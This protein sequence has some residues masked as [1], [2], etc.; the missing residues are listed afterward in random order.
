MKQERAVEV[1]QE[2]PLYETPYG[3]G[4][5][6]KIEIVKGK[7]DVKQ[8]IIK[9]EHLDDIDG[10]LNDDIVLEEPIEYVN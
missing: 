9:K 10:L 3:K 7:D 5:G 6:K 2:K 1:K 4:N 8:I